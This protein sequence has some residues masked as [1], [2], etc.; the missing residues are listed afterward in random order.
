MKPMQKLLRNIL[1]TNGNNLNLSLRIQEV[2]LIYRRGTS[3]K[4]HYDED[5]DHN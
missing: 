2:E 3:H 1:R 5:D 4:R